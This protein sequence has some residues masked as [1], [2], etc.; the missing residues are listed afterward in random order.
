[1]NN[2]NYNGEIILYQTEDNKTKIQVKLVNETVWLSLNQLVVLFQRDKSVISRHIKNIFEEGELNENSVVAFFATTANDG[3]TYKVEYFNLDV[4][5]AVGYRVKSHR[6]TQFRIWASERLKEYIVKG[7]TM[8]DQRLK[9]VKNIGTDYF[10]EMLE[11]IRD[12][13]SSEK[14]FY[15]KIRDIYKMAVDYDPKSEDTLEFFKIVQNKLHFAI[16]GKTAAEIIH[17]RA[18]AHKSNMGL[19]SWAGTKLR[20]SD[21]TIAKNYLNQDELEQLNSIVTM[22]LD[23]AED[24]AKRRKQIFMKD[25]RDKLDAFLKFNERE[26][27]ENSGSISKE[28]AEKLALEQYEIYHQYRLNIEAKEEDQLDDMDLI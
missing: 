3:K 15:Q 14:R 12:I 17:E 28:I 20:K 26:I 10:D 16:S 19:T 11:R 22:Y 25:W 4:I 1:M 13:R 2:S 18:D 6:G 5:I 27:L 23:Y 7:F 8:D 24:Q 9:D 21:V